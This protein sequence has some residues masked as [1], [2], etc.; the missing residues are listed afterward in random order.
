MSGQAGGSDEKK[1]T[2]GNIERAVIAVLTTRFSDWRLSEIEISE[3][4]ARSIAA[5]IIQAA[6]EDNLQRQ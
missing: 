1:L 6:E 4:E 3:R 5:D 2:R